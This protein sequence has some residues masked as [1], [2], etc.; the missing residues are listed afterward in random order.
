MACGC[1]SSGVHGAY[2]GIFQRGQLSVNGYRYAPSRVQGQNPGM[3]S[4]GLRPPEA[5]ALH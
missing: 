5:E 1:A 2:P 3:G 4:A